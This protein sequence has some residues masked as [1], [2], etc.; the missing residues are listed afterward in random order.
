MREEDE[1]PR[2]SSRAESDRVIS[3][4]LDLLSVSQIPRAGGGGAASTLI[5]TG[6]KKVS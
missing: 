6:D 4:L 5:I 3:N 2:W 1:G